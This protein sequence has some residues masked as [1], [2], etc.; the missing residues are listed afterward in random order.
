MKKGPTGSMTSFVLIM[1][2]TGIAAII[3][4]ADWIGTIVFSVAFTLGYVTG[5]KIQDRKMRKEVYDYGDE[6]LDTD[7]VQ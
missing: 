7:K 1:F 4:G 3:N 5:N 6:C 2:F